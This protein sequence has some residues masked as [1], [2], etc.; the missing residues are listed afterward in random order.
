MPVHDIPFPTPS[1]KV[2]HVDEDLFGG[3]RDRLVALA[4]EDGRVSRSRPRAYAKEPGADAPSHNSESFSASRLPEHPISADAAQSSRLLSP[5]GV[6][7]SGSRGPAGADAHSLSLIR[8]PVVARCIWAF[9]MLGQYDGELFRIL[10]RLGQVGA[11][12]LED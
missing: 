11:I 7:A 3:I 2:G 4:Q 9:A 6:T 10:T 5:P 8:M 12:V 1:M